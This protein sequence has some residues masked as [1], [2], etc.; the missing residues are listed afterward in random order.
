MSQSVD[1]R[2]IRACIDRRPPPKT[3][4]E[5]MA[6]VKASLWQPGDIIRIAF[7]DGDEALR[8]RVR[9]AAE[10]WADYA[11]LK[12]YWGELPDADVRISFTE[13]GSWSYIGTDCRGIPKDSPTMN[14]G[15]LSNDTAQE[16]VNR[17]VLHEFGHALGCIHEHQNPEGGIKWNRPVVYAYFAGPPNFWSNDDVDHN[18]F[19]TYDANLTVH[20]RLDAASIMMYPID[21][22]FTTDGFEVGLNSELSETDKRFIAEM[23]S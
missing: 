19:D 11:D 20:T 1:A 3:S 8:G 7:M 4:A 14:Y 13:T 12:L 18:I 15:W 2:E 10:L 5:R 9:D 21:A 16:E 6:L 17:V 22:S 23:Y